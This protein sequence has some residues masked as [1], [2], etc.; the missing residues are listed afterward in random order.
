M[1]NQL[2]EI[3]AGRGGVIAPK[4]RP[5]ICTGIG[6]AEIDYP[7][8]SWHMALTAIDTQLTPSC[9]GQGMTSSIEIM[10]AAHDG[11]ILRLDG[12]AL[13]EY[14]R[15]LNYGDLDGGLQVE[16]GIDAVCR[17]GL[18]P[19]DVEIYRVP[20][21][22]KSINDALQEGPLPIA[23]CVHQG[24]DRDQMSDNGRINEWVRF[25]PGVGGHMTCMMANADLGGVNLIGSV[26][27]WGPDYGKGG[28]FFMSAVHFIS[29]AIDEP[30]LFR[31]D[32]AWWSS[33]EFAAAAEKVRL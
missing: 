24:W 8:V 16:E 3:M 10:S 33:A 13:W 25:I 11:P 12:E 9:V 2:A 7:D 20:L 1:I 18:V 27:S 4:H 15:M 21:D 32:H 30:V 19:N 29:C 5:A 6:G 26:N 14:E 31:V 17:F 22:Q 23:T 28:V